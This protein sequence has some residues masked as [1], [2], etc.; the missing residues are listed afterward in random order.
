MLLSATGYYW[1]PLNV[2][3]LVLLDT[4]RFYWILRDATG[5]TRWSLAF[6]GGSRWEV[7]NFRRI[8]RITLE[9]LHREIHIWEVH[10][11]NCQ[12]NLCTSPEELVSVARRPRWM[13]IQ[14]MR[15]F[16]NSSGSESPSGIL[17]LPELSQRKK[18]NKNARKVYRISQFFQIIPDLQ[19]YYLAVC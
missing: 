2:T 13:R 1:V 15:I 12:N 8:K 5:C 7:H 3:G 9:D 11:F 18:G 19:A 14:K 16:I 4:T 17:S 10:N 6:L